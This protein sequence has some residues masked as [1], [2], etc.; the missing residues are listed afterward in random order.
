MCMLLNGIG[1]LQKLLLCSL[2]DCPRLWTDDSMIVDVNPKQ[3]HV[4]ITTNVQQIFMTQIPDDNQHPAQH[5][6]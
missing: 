1:P 2:S 6:S 5:D 3:L 4:H